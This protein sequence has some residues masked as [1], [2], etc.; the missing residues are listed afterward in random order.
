MKLHS[1]RLQT[2]E[3]VMPDPRDS[4]YIRHSQLSLLRQRVYGMALGYEDI[5]DHDPVRSDP[6]S[7]LISSIRVKSAAFNRCALVS[8]RPR[9]SNTLPLPCSI[10][11][12]LMFTYPSS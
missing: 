7:R 10:F 9:F 11:V 8:G 3:A 4:R 12:S 5:N 2:V 1:Q 6:V